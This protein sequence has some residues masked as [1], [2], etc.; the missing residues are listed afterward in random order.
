[1]VG[2]TSS[3]NQPNG[4]KTPIVVPW[5]KVYLTIGHPL[6]LTPPI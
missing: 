4:T 5:V 6:G 1:L 2:S 3:F